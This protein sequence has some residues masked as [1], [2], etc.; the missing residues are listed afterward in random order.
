MSSI[1]G[2]TLVAFAIA[3]LGVLTIPG[4]NTGKMGTNAGS[5]GASTGAPSAATNGNGSL[6]TSNLPRTSGGASSGATTQ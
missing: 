3:A 1:L 4:C 5:A 6:G 2:R